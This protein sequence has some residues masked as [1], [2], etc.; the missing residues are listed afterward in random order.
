MA[1]YMYS[2]NGSVVHLLLNENLANAY[3]RAMTSWFQAQ[4]DFEEIHGRKITADEVIKGKLRIS[5]SEEEGLAWN[6][7]AC[8]INGMINDGLTLKEE[9]C[10]SIY[11]EKL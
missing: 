7:I 5:V 1:T 4:K 6:K 10:T 3:N 11:L 2:Y 9:D 8:I